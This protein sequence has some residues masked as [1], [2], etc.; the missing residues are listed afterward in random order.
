LVVSGDNLY[1]QTISLICET[2]LALTDLEGLALVYI[3]TFGSARL[4]SAFAG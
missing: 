1:F 3:F 4:N 2:N